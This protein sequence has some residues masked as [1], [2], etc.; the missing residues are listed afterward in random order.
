[1]PNPFKNI[2]P[3]TYEDSNQD[4]LRLLDGGLD[5]EVDPLAPLLVPAR[6]V[7]TI[8]C[9]DAVRILSPWRNPLS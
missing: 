9:V 8:L 1:M 4:E 6:G 2:N 3:T 5:G 7:D